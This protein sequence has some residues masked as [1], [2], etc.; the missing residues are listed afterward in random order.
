MATQSRNEIA[1]KSGVNF[2]GFV[3]TG[4]ALNLGY[5]MKKRIFPESVQSAL[6]PRRVSRLPFAVRGFNFGAIA[7]AK[8][9]YFSRSRSPHKARPGFR[10]TDHGDS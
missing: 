8:R 5:E 1:R 9:R 6:P 2:K 10:L 4:A 3:D 7:S